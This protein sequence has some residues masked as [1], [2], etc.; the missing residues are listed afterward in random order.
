MV[1]V[2]SS[3]HDSTGT[4]ADTDFETVLA[5][6]GDKEVTLE[7]P[8]IPPHDHTYRSGESHG[9]GSSSARTN[10]L[11]SSHNNLSTDDTGGGEAHNNLQ[12]YITVYMWKRIT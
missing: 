7:V 1:G 11:H 9:P 5:T 12:P 2:Q 8:Q 3:A 10:E 6:G 4:G